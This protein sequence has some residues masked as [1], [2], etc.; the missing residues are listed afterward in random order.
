[1][2][3]CA[4]FPPFHNFDWIMQNLRV[5]ATFYVSRMVPTNR[6]MKV[7]CNCTMVVDDLWVKTIKNMR[8]LGFVVLLC[9]K[10]ALSLRV[11]AGQGRQESHVI[12][13]HLLFTRAPRH[14]RKIR[15]EGYALFS[16]ASQQKGCV[17]GGPE[18]RNPSFKQLK[19]QNPIFKQAKIQNLNF[20]KS[21]SKFKFSNPKWEQFLFYM[22]WWN[23]IEG[24]QP[25]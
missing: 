4:C 13:A 22:Q 1:M 5:E 18:I 23:R 11:K 25:I 2:M 24:W 16:R 17:R 19:I 14:N 9:A 21:N 10:C 15:K 7:A 8:C 20:L 12:P 3:P 6:W